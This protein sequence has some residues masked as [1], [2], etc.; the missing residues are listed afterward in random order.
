MKRRLVTAMIVFSSLTALAGKAERD[1]ISKT[2]EPAVKDAQDK[3]KA[4][5]GCQLDITVD[6]SSL[7]KQDDIRL[8][9]YMA[10]DISKNAPKYCTDAA[11]KKAMCQLKT[12]VFAKTKPAE[13]TFKAGKGQLSHDGQGHATWEMMTRVLDK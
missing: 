2:L 12:L 11:S 6:D 8:S 7:Q 1:Q 9:K 5:C 10:E 13:F 3:F 4:S